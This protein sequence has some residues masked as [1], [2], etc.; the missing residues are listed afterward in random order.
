MPKALSAEQLDHLRWREKLT[1]AQLRAIEGAGSMALRA[2]GEQVAHL[3]PI[4][5]L[6]GEPAPQTMDKA[7]VLLR[8]LADRTELSPHGVLL[9]F[10]AGHLAAVTAADAFPS[11][12]L[13]CVE[14]KGVRPW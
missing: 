12:L 4:D 11:V 7:F 6:D 5:S 8:R 3:G 2:W 1:R 13:H 10:V 14:G 9:A